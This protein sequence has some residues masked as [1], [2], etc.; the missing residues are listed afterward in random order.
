MSK[1][2]QISEELF[3]DIWILMTFP[4]LPD[5][6]YLHDSVLDRINDKIDK[7]IDREL[8]T[9]YKTAPTKEEREKARQEYLSRK[10]IPQNFRW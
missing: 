4:E 1:N 2:V 9:R 10:G 6:D 5:W 3:K 7:I 8:Y